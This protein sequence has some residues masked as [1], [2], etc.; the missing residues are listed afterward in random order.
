MALT[1]ADYRPDDAQRRRT[2]VCIGTGI[3]SVEE[4]VSQGALLASR[5]R[6]A[7]SAYSVTRLLPNMASGQVSIAHAF[8]G[9][10]LCPSTACTTGA[11]SIGDAYQCIQLG[12]ADVMIAGSTEAP[13]TPLSMALFSRCRA[14]STSF[15]DRPQSASRPFSPDR[16][17]FIMG[18]GAGIIVLESLEHA[19]ARNA[20]I[21]AEVVGYGMS[22]DAHHITQPGSGAI[23]AMRSAISRSGLAPSQI[24]Y[25]NAHATSTPLGDAVENAAIKTVFAADAKSL[26][27]SSTKGAVGHMLGASGSVEA[28]FTILAIHHNTAPPT[29]NFDPKTAESEFDLNYVPISTSEQQAETQDDSSQARID[30]AL[31]NSFGFGGTNASLIFKRFHHAT[32]R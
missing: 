25:V 11:H 15:N 13:I 22:G 4:S 3:G 32:E 2:G 19:R 23:D 30:A 29:L 5:G 14:L 20:R 24:Q 27:V 26:R 28:I 18:E 12:H 7:V 16:D 1:D 21:L 9:P 17:G 6:R 8:R 31:T 10:N